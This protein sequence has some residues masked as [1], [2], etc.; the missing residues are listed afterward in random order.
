MNN[1]M[2]RCSMAIAEVITLIPAKSNYSEVVKKCHKETSSRTAKNT[3]F[4]I[5]RN[6][7][8]NYKE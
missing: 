7:S 2:K 4:R 6:P 8:Q 3:L 5:S 1:L